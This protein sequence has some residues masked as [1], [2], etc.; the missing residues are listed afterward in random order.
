ME[1]SIVPPTA[2]DSKERIK[3]DQTL[4][5]MVSCWNCGAYDADM[6]QFLQTDAVQDASSSKSMVKEEDVSNNV[7]IKQEH[8]D[9]KV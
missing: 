3:E 5:Q 8:N 2:E 9:D 6:T 1:S 7:I 4:E